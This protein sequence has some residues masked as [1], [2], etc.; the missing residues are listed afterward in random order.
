MRAPG[1][2]QC[3]LVARAKSQTRAPKL[4]DDAENLLWAPE[5]AR[6]LNPRSLG[7]RRTSLPPGGRRFEREITAHFDLTLAME[8][9]LPPVGVS[10]LALCDCTLHDLKGEAVLNDKII[11]SRQTKE[12]KAAMI[13]AKVNHGQG[14][15]KSS[16]C[17][18]DWRRVVGTGEMYA[19]CAH[20]TSK[21]CS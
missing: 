5:T 9:R 4:W 3:A 18:R 8:A 11:Y 2:P 7:V 16:M 14:P 13:R 15:M 10:Q 17:G 6:P 1:T 19:T 20:P 21:S 12:N